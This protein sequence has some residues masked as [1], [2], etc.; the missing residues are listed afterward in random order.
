LTNSPTFNEIRQPAQ[1]FAGCVFNGMVTSKTETEIFEAWV[2][3]LA[4]YADEPVRTARVHQNAESAES[5]PALQKV[6]AGPNRS[7]GGYFDYSLWPDRERFLELD[8]A[9]ASGQDLRDLNI[10]PETGVF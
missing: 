10:E 7:L 6:A 1:G 8:K 9:I 4:K 3:A 5:K 2:A